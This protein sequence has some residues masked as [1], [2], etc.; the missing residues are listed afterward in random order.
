MVVEDREQGIG[1]RGQGNFGRIGVLMGGPSS[2]REISLRS[3]TAVYEALKALKPDVVNL[4]IIDNDIE[5]VRAQIKK[6]GVKVAFIAL[7]GRFGEDG[8]IQ[9]LLEEMDIPY[10]GSGIFASR[11]ALNKIAARD[12]FKKAGLLI[13]RA[14]ILNK[15]NPVINNFKKLPVVVKPATSGSSIGLTIVEKE[16][17]LGQ[18]LKEAFNHDADV[19]LEEY[20]QGRECTV[21]ILEERPLPVIEIIPKTKFFDYQAKY[22]KGMTEYIVPANLEKGVYKRVQ[23]AG[24]SAH[25]ALGCSGFSRSDIIIDRFDNP[26]VL[27]LNTI[28]GMTQTSLLPKAAASEGINFSELCLKLLTLALIADKRKIC[29]GNGKR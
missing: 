28:P 2:E 4:D 22:T 15:N 16:E 3:G 11:L 7:H 23:E 21:S 19:L 25:K 14:Q 26:Y 29:A 10:T 24:L 18:A 9:K 17:G 1:S 27:E 5:M 12:I 8:I 20:I 13:P 6:A